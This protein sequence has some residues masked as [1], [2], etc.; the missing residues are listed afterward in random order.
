MVSSDFSASAAP[1]LGGTAY[2]SFVYFA[3]FPARADIMA[4]FSAEDHQNQSPLFIFS[5][6]LLAGLNME[7]LARLYRFD[8]MAAW[9]PR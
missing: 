4:H 7:L 9:S 6:L 8:S 1:Y 2:S 5:S 3:P